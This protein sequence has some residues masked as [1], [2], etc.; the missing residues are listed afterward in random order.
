MQRSPI[1]FWLLLAATGAVG[2]VALSGFW[3]FGVYGEAPSAAVG[4]LYEAWTFAV[5]SVVTIGVVFAPRRRWVGLLSLVGVVA[6]IAALTAALADLHVGE[7][8]AFYASHVTG[9]AI[10]LWIVKQTRLW[11]D[12]APSPR[13][14]RWQFSVA[15]LL[16]LMTL[17]AVLIA[18]LRDGELAD[19]HPVHILFAI[20]ATS[21]ALGV[22]AVAIWLRPWRHAMFRL[23]AMLAAGGVIGWAAEAAVFPLSVMAVQSCLLEVVLIFAWLELGRIIPRGE[24]ADGA[25]PPPPAPS[26]T[27]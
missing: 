14:S 27:T 25:P 2:A 6:V 26:Q 7:T 20:V 9:L 5:L 23:A 12:A 16:L 24:P 18:S 19:R 17:V 10:S 21:V 8:A 1:I 4:A 3:L 11:R 15:Q 22:A 13:P